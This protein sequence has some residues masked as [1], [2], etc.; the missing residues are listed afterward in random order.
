MDEVTQEKLKQ[1]VLADLQK[2][3]VIDQIRAQLRQQVFQSLAKG[4][5]VSKKDLTNREVLTVSVISDWLNNHGF[6][7]TAATLSSEAQMGGSI[8][9]KT[10]VKSELRI[11]KN[12][13]RSILDS[14]ID[15]HLTL[16]PATSK[17]NL[18]PADFIHSL[19]K[20]DSDLIVFKN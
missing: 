19:E 14:I 3:G 17:E 4:N 13:D 2:T 5:K 15:T 11:D 9:P 1:S 20:E 16:A 8:L 10:V 12:D 6:S 7:A 18:P